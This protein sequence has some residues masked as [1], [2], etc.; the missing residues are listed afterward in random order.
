MST[1]K[2]TYLDRR[3][4]E[5]KPSRSYTVEFKD[6]RERRQRVSAFVDKRASEELERRLELLARL[7]RRGEPLTAELT[8]YVEALPSRVRTKL[9]KVGVL[10][11]RRLEA[12]KPLVEHLDDYRAWLEGR[13]NAPLYVSNTVAHVRAM[14]DGTGAGHWSDLDALK[15]EAHLAS[16]REGGLSPT[17]T[18]HYLRDLRSFVGWLVR[19]GLAAEDPLR[20]I[21][22]VK[23]AADLKRK[24]RAATA[25]EARALLAATA[26]GP[27]RAGLTGA[28]RAML[29]RVALETGFRASELK[30]LRVASFDL[31]EP[32]RATVRVEAAYSKRRRE[33][34]APLRPGTAREL[35]AFLEGRTRWEPAFPLPK[36]W[37]SAAMLR[38]D[39]KAAGIPEEDESGRRLDFHALRVSFVSALARAGVAHKAAQ[40]LA[41]HSSPALTFNVYAKLGADDERTA[42]E[43]LPDLGP[44]GGE[45]EARA[46]GTEGKKQ[47]GCTGAS[48]GEPCT[49]HGETRGDERD[50]DQPE[51]PSEAPGGMAER[52]GFEPAVP[53]N[54]DTRL[55]I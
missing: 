9:T 46:T 15:V 6:H 16:L 45:E 13:G 27:V 54:G 29:Y 18:N 31:V 35:A 49:R 4:G 48:T 40:N 30:S 14:L 19:H 7:R 8:R 36:S 5:R 2:D 26:A 21:K 39:L 52:A 37:R 33:D 50:R 51:P 24:R 25:K 1:Y 42:L 38:E 10:D 53:E 44:E 55:A 34:V 12:A 23:V 43:A 32:E 41:R 22:P 20:V 3:T 11:A 28:E 17:T 47:L